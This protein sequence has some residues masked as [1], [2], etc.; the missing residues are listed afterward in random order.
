LYKQVFNYLDIYFVKN[1]NLEI[2]RYIYITFI[3]LVYIFIHTNLEINC[4]LKYAYIYMYT[5]KYNM[6]IIFEGYVSCVMFPV[7]CVL[8][9]ISYWINNMWLTYLDIAVR[10]W[11][12]SVGRLVNNRDWWRV[13]D[14][15]FFLHWLWLVSL[16]F[17]FFCCLFHYLY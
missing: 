16:M 7:L 5:N 2:W 14:V 6:N 15:H 9:H 12:Y 17:I 4:L 11:S 13:S 3:Y 1:S 8:F 10:M